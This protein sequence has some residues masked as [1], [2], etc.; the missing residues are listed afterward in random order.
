VIIIIIILISE[1]SNFFPRFETGTFQ[2]ALDKSRDQNKFLLIYLHSPYHEYTKYFLSDV[3]CKEDV[4]TYMN[5]NFVLWGQSINTL[6]G[7]KF[8]NR[9]SI[10]TFP[11]MALICLINKTPQFTGVLQSLGFNNHISL[12]NGVNFLHHWQGE[13]DGVVLVDYLSS[14]IEQYD[15]VLE[16]I[17]RDKEDQIINRTLMQEQDRAYLDSIKADEEKKRKKKKKKKK[18]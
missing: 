6:E 15:V 5:E 3:L 7:L 10:S 2:E 8:F 1:I 11:F 9:Y 17:K 4:A 16:A 13:F 14:I 12:R 18:F